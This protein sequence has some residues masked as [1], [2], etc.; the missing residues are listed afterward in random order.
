MCAHIKTFIAYLEYSHFKICQ[1]HLHKAEKILKHQ[2]IYA[3]CVS[4]LIKCLENGNWKM[5]GIYYK[6]MY[7]VVMKILL[8]VMTVMQATNLPLLIEEYICIPHP[9]HS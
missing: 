9:L 8:L 1:L 4:Y 3:I 5:T 2:K 6:G 7:E